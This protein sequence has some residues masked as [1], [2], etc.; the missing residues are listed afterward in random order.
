MAIKPPRRGKIG[1]IITG[2]GSGWYA[3][4]L[5]VPKYRWNPITDT[6]DMLADWLTSRLMEIEGFLKAE[7]A[8]FGATYDE[9]VA[10]MSYEVRTTQ[11]DKERQDRTPAWSE[12]VKVPVFNDHIQRVDLSIDEAV[13]R[14]RAI[15]DNNI[16]GA[17]AGVE[18]L[19]KYDFKYIRA[20]EVVIRFHTEALSTL[21]NSEKAREFFTEQAK[22]R[23]T[24]IMDHKEKNRKK[25]K[26]QVREEKKR[27]RS[28]KA[29]VAGV[30]GAKALKRKI[31]AMSPEEKAILAQAFKDRAAKAATTKRAKIAAMTPEQLA[32]HQAKLSKAAKK[33]ARTRRKANKAASQKPAKKGG[34]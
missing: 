23:I 6:G 10:T 32:K 3:F 14:I 12:G 1:D 20:D 34:K 24:T 27:I 13:S 4:D 19:E 2:E 21:P 8:K 26:R 16:A 29:A 28:E 15:G 18:M 11:T 7:A 5:P 17:R 9:F 22:Q 33:G 31:E 30:E 25:R